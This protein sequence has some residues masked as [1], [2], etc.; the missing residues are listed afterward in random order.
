MRGSPFSRFDRELI[1]YR[2]GPPR[3]TAVGLS[4]LFLLALASFAAVTTA[5][6]DLAPVAQ[7]DTSLQQ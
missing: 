1:H 3:R 4:A 5:R 2:A 7:A 6:P